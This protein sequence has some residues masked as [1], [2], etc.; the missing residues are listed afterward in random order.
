[1]NRTLAKGRNELVVKL[2]NAGKSPEKIAE[3]VGCCADNVYRILRSSGVKF[4]YRKFTDEQLESLLNEGKSKSECSRILGV[5]PNTIY[6]RTKR[7]ENPVRNYINESEI[8]CMLR[9]REN[10]YA[11]EQIAQRMG[12]TA[13]SVRN[14]IGNQPAEITSA[15]KVYAHAV[16]KLNIQ[17]RDSAKMAMIRRK[18]EEERI[19]AERRAAEEAA[20]REKEALEKNKREIFDTFLSIGFPQELATSA[21]STIETAAQGA[22]IL[23]NMKKKFAAAPAAVH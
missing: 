13:R 17:R 15:S 20:R 4:R 14:H 1:M 6:R 5:N 7:I 23:A 12:L 16:H 18:Q 3:I 10:G 22:A 21:S 11:N 2:Y 9:L 19:E 8:A